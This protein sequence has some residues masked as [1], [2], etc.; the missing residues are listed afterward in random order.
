VSGAIGMDPIYRELPASVLSLVPALPSLFTSIQWFD[1]D[2]FNVATVSVDQTEA[3]VTYYDN[4][5]GV[6]KTYNIPA[7]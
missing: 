6:L 1:I 7:T 5:G 4:T 2:R 3:D